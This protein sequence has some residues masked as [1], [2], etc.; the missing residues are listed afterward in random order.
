MHSTVA[1]LRDR[2]RET[3][4]Q[5][6]G[7]M[8]W[9]APIPAFG[10]VSNAEVATVGLK[11]SNREFVNEAGEE[12]AGTARRFHTLASFQLSDWAEA[13]ARH[14]RL[15]L[16]SCA[17]Y[18]SRNPYDTWFKRLDEILSGTRFSLYSSGAC[19]LDLIPYAT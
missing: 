14:I 16:D 5:R 4:L 1:P 15:M 12:L 3:N 7:V 10:D 18:F 17:S 6:G 8:P 9:A 11:P 13:D 19:H 2:L